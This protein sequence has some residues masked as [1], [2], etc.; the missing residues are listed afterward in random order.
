MKKR[1]LEMVL[2]AAALAVLVGCAEKKPVLHIYTWSD[3]VKPELVTRF[4]TENNCRVVIDTYDSNEAMYAKLKAGATGYDLLFPSSYMVKIMNDQNMLRKLD[5]AQLPNLANIDPDYLAMAFDKTMEHSVP[6]TVTITC[7]GYLDGKVKDFTPSWGMLDR[8]DLRNRMTMLNDH[9]ETIGAALKFLGYS[10][11]TLDDQ[12]LAE[13]KDV[14]LRWK[15]NL[16]KFENEQYKTG[17]AS[18]EFLLTHGY[19]GDLMLVQSENEDI[20]IAVPQE[21]SALSFDDMVIPTDARQVELAHKF[22]NFILD[23]AVAAE[24]TEYIYFLCPNRPSYSLLPP[25]IQADPILFPPPEV[26]AKLEMIGDLGENNVKY[27]KLWDAI[28]AGE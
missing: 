14:V 27:T 4:E 25:E 1:V 12:Q 9:R 10:L 11:N 5:P 19:S 6:Y 23:P 16:A 18:G 22:I 15:K 24:L 28:K 7:L 2:A 8:E 21:G 13:A 17:L 3:Y 26:I 20:Q